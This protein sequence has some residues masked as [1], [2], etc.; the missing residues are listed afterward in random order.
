MGEKKNE[1]KNEKVF[2]IWGWFQSHFCVC[3]VNEVTLFVK[4]IDTYIQVSR[5][6]YVLKQCHVFYQLLF[7]VLKNLQVIF[8]YIRM[9]GFGGLFVPVPIP[10]PIPIPINFL[11]ANNL[12]TA[13][14]D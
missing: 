7:V 5:L 8:L 3:L 12:T 11:S 6:Y 9:H 13:T 4:Y 14:D 1:K 10:L 2:E